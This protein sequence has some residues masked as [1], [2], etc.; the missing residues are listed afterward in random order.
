MQKNGTDQAGTMRRPR[1]GAIVASALA[2]FAAPTAALAVGDAPPQSDPQQVLVMLRIP[3]EHARTGS[4]YSGGYGD[5]LGRAARRRIAQGL[6]KA[7]G[8]ALV[9]DWPMPLLNLDCYVMAVPPGQSPDVVAGSLAREPVVAEAEAS[10]TFHAEGALAPAADPLFMVQ[11]AAREWRLASLHRIA[12]GRGVRVAVV[13]S[14]IDARHPDLEGQV[15][16]A[17]NFVAGPVPGPEFHGT[18]VAGVIA[19]RGG[20]GVGIDG[21]APGASLLALRACW[22]QPGRMATAC[23]T[24]SLA[25]ALQFAIG[26][27]AQVINLSLSGPADPLLGRLIDVART[28]RIQVVAAYDRNARYGGFPADHPGVVAVIDETLAAAPPG[29]YSAPG[30]DVPTTAPGGKWSIVN[31]S[32]FA[33]AHVSGLVALMRERRPQNSADRLAAGPG[34]AIDAC[35]SLAA[36]ISCS[37]PPPSRDRAAR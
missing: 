26:H 25:K 5:Q 36:G 33:A 15:S 34:G 1:A 7:H 17:Q 27:R 35:A 14:M 2:L 37:T 21:V 18:A 28:D 30:R 31:G 4:D 29:V 11:P 32:S 10:R 13:D 23:D 3:P 6:A 20:N 8:L 22:Q 12:T 16:L 19:A 24:F 9:D